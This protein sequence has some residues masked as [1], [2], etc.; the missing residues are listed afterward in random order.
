MI[1]P[2]STRAYKLE[3]ENREV[4]KEIE[5]LNNIVEEYKNANEY[6][7]NII[8]ELETMKQPNQLYSENVKLRAENNR[9]N[10]II[11]EYT[12]WLEA[13]LDD[14]FYWFKMYSKLQDLKK[15]LIKSERNKNNF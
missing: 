13:H 3:K 2:R 9:L 11:N 15:E 14:E 10:N 1:D 6:H 8:H 4:K 7:Q 12:K 5:R